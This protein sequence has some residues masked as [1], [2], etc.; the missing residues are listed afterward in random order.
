MSSVIYYWTDARQH[1][2]YLLNR[3]TEL[4]RAVDVMMARAKRI[5]ILMVE[6]NKFIFFFVSRYF[7]KEIENM[8]FVFLSSY[9]NT[10]ES[11]GELEKAV[12]TLTCDSCSHS[13]SRSPKLSLVF[14]LN[15]YTI[16]QVILAFW[17]VLSY[18]L[19][20]DRYTIDVITTIFLH[21]RTFALIVSAHPY[22]ARNLHATSCIERAR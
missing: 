14:L 5:Y 13:I 22:C 9:R 4:V 1:G 7:L 10:R 17:L 18:D 3:N 20:E 21:L 11:L 15:N 2:I 19:L 6:V 16:A 12:E 8:F